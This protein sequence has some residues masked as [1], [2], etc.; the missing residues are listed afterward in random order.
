[1]MKTGCFDKTKQSDT[2]SINPGEW[3]SHFKELLGKK[4]ENSEEQALL[5]YVKQNRG[6]CVSEL[7]DSFT[8]KNVLDAI[9]ALKN[10]KASSFDSVLNEM[11]KCG[12]KVLS[13]ALV[14]FFN[15]ILDS[16]LYPKQ[17]KMDILGPL[18]KSG[19]L[20]DA[21]NFRGV[22]VSSCLGKLFNTLLRQ[23]LDQFCSKNN[24]INKYQG[25]GKSNS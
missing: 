25:S 9:K 14:V 21:N 4:S 6:K 15:T 1:M 22:C 17:W 18:H 8:E 13:K 23:K 11:L 7:D 24:L 12:A 16:N 20:D 5:D 19:P 2:D 3:F 10:N